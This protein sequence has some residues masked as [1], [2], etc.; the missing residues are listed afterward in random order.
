MAMMMMLTT[1]SIVAM[2]WMICKGGDYCAERG[3]IVV[4]WLLRDR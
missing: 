1:A 2:H 3:E 4:L